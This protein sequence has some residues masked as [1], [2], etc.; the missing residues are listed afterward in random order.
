MILP[1]ILVC[2]ILAIFYVLLPVALIMTEKSEKFQHRFA[3]IASVVFFVGLLVGVL[4]KIDITETKVSLSFD[5]SG[6]WF[7]KRL[8][9][10]FKTTLA[11][12]IINILML[13]PVGEM[14]CFVSKKRGNKLGIV[15][16]LLVGL[17]FGFVIE[18]LQFA[19][20]VPRSVQISDVVF[21]MFSTVIGYLY[22]SGL[23]YFKKG[24][25]KLIKKRF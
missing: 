12:K 6:E 13:I 25:G 22:F 8:N 18:F 21:N 23:Y 5:F 19:L 14:V 7:E 10:T 1:T 9:T 20:P 11:D 4:G 15:W 2:V 3:L 24:L 17:L 16:S